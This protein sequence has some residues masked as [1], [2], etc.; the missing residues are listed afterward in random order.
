M[1]RDQR[2]DRIAYGAAVLVPIAVGLA[3]YPARGH[4]VEAN[5]A[6]VYVVCIVAVAS[7]GRRGAAAV[8]AVVSALSFD[9]FC[10]RPYLSLR[11]TKSAD[12]TTEL[13]LLVVG[14]AVG[15][16]AARG[17]GA[18]RQA[19]AGSERLSRIHGVGERIA[20]GEDPDFV[21][22]A[23]AQE[24]RDVLSLRDCRFTREP[25]SDAGARIEADGTV[26]M[27]GGVWDAERLGLPTRKVELAVRGEGQVLGAFLLTPE[28]ALPIEHDRC[29]LAVALADQLGTVLSGR[30]LAG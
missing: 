4:I 1:T 23:V 2:F 9:Y 7:A 14:L 22:M 6:L 29:V 26:T 3:L 28:P 25:V 30:R 17:R 10:T 20:S 12:L 5:L 11:I 27:A 15:E 21:V 16:L 8:T 19:R 13:L 24:L 18:R